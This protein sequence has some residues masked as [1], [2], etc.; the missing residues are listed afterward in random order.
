V[1][2][3]AGQRR[4]PHRRRAVRA[5]G[6]IGQDAHPEAAGLAAILAHPG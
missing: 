3:A 6:E 4:G 1:P 5:Q 2:L